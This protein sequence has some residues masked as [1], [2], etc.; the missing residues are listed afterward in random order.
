[1]LCDIETPPSPNGWPTMRMPSVPPWVPLSFIGISIP[2][3]P[4]AETGL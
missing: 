1:M 4:L 3:R 2:I